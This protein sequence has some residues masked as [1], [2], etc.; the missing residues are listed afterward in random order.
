MPPVLV[1]VA[2]NDTLATILKDVLIQH[3]IEAVVASTDGTR[4]YLPTSWIEVEG[5][6]EQSG[7]WIAD[8]KDQAQADEIVRDFAK[9]PGQ[10]ATSRWNWRCPKCGEEV[11]AQFTECWKCGTSRTP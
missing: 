2:A 5:G 9:G 10:Q 4:H 7:V 1:H 8:E 3:G 11:E 6:P